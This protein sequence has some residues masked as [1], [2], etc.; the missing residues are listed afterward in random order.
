MT[1]TWTYTQPVEILFQNGIANEID[2][3]LAQRGFTKGV[4]VCDEFFVDS[5]PNVSPK[6]TS[7]YSDI[8]PNPTI[9]NA[10]NCTDAILA[11]DAEF[12]LA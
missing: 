5:W 12:V 8:Q 1:K 6:I 9:E 3:L 4:L 2:N 11:T 10:Q 7:I